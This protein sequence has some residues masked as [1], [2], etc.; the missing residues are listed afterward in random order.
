M[1]PITN[2]PRPE[3]QRIVD[4]LNGKLEYQGAPIGAADDEAQQLRSEKTPPML[5]RL[6]QAWQSSGP[7]LFIFSVDHRNMWADVERY[8]KT[9]H[10]QLTGTR[11]SGAA[12]FFVNDRVERDP[13]D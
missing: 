11:G 3:L 2:R 9:L 7:D 1:L 12:G 6:V 5:R 8:W 10:I 4:S 13:Y